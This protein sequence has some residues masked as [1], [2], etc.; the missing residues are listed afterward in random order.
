MSR[1]EREAGVERWRSDSV[2]MVTPVV[3]ERGKGRLQGEDDTR[4]GLSGRRNGVAGSSGGCMLQA[5]E[6]H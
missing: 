4:D 2:A 6:E 1:R 5:E 3:G